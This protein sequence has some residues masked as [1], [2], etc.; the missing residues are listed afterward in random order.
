MK[1]SLNILMITHKTNSSALPRSFTLAKEIVK[2]GHR[3]T[4]ML[5]S[6]VHRVRFEDYYVDGVHVVESPDMLWGRLRTGWDPWDTLR[7]IYYFS[8]T[9]EKYDLIHCFETRPATIYPAL[10]LSRK[11]HSPIITDWNDWWGHHGLI[12]VNRPI[13]YPLTFGWLETYYEEAF[14]SQAAGLTVIASALQK[15]GTDL[16]VDPDRICHI[17][18]GTLADVSGF[19]KIE[20]CREYTK[21]PS[22]GPVLGFS[23]ADSHLD[24]EIIM[25]AMVIVAKKYPSV[26]LIITGQAKK[27]VFEMV[28]KN[29][30][31]NRV[32]FSGFLSREDYPIFLGSA[33][34]FLLPMADRPYN[35]GRWPNKMCDYLSVGRPTVS[36]PVGDIKTLFENHEIGLL[37]DWSPEDFAEKIIYL[38]DHPELSEKF[39]KNALIVAQNEFNWRTLAE[40][41]ETF[42]QHIIRLEKNGA[43]SKETK[44]LEQRI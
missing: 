10:Y 17:P 38:L 15:R 43:G 19:R 7:R 36:N 22:E 34:M 25:Q 3:V 23:S 29:G 26:K 12:E 24:L 31:H 14:R 16:G 37:A 41:T 28:R 18:G 42:Y 30:L 6:K 21:I 9:E 5:I 35:R 20:D 44:E 33:D 11:D 2:L 13:W 4:I 39:S 32:I 27:E 1:P 40:K 8:Q